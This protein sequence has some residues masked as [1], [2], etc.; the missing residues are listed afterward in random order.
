M[1]DFLGRIFW[2]VSWVGA[3]LAGAS[4]A[5]AVDKAPPARELRAY[6]NCHKSLD[7][8]LAFAHYDDTHGRYPRTAWFTCNWREEKYPQIHLKYPIFVL[9]ER[10]YVLTDKNFYAFKNPHPRPNLWAGYLDLSNIDATENLQRFCREP[11]QVIQLV[12]DIEPR[13]IV[14]ALA[15]EPLKEDPYWTTEKV[16]PME[17]AWQQ[18]REEIGFELARYIRDLPELYAHARGNGEA[19]TRE[20]DAFLA[21]R[22]EVIAVAPQCDPYLAL[23]PG[24]HTNPKCRALLPAPLYEKYWD[25]T[26]VADPKRFLGEPPVLGDWSAMLSIAQRC[27]VDT[28]DLSIAAAT[29]QLPAKLEE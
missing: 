15:F 3:V 19:F 6:A 16:A 4:S 27:A 28:G 22:D 2:A 25:L 9:P 21:T 24:R 12:A 8:A 1:S 11:H 23:S 26:R 13:R 29:K 7:E 18:A 10:A 20:R 14:R 5:Q 17:M